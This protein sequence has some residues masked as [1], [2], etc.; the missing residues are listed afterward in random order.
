MTKRTDRVLLF[1]MF[2]NNFVKINKRKSFIKYIPATINT[3]SKI[4]FKFKATS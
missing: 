1:F 2:T 3:K 4:T